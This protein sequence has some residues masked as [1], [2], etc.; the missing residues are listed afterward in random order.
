M[1]KP[2]F[3]NVAALNRRPMMTTVLPAQEPESVAAVLPAKPAK[4][5]KA[6]PSSP[7]PEIAAVEEAPRGVRG[8]QE[9]RRP[10]RRGKRAVTFWVNPEPHK[11]L[12]LLGVRE[13]RPAQDLME[14]ALN[15]L[16]AKYGMNRIA[17]K[18]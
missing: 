7:A 1:K 2:S 9:D 10:I 4:E 12:K 6:V 13:E 15:D 8:D 3:S 14:E 17:R 16:F 11:Q 5:R 18:N